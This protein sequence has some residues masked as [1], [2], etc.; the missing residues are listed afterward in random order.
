MNINKLERLVAV[1][2]AGSFRK[3][4][5]V[6]GLSQPAL[7]WSIR[8]LE[9]SLDTPL[10]ERGPRGAVPTLACERLI[11]RA[12]LVINAQQRLMAEIERNRGLE[13][14]E[15]GVHPAMLHS[16]FAQ[17]VARYYQSAPEVSLRIREGYSADLLADLQRGDLDLAVCA[18]PASSVDQPFVFEPLAVQTYSVVAHPAHPVFQDIDAGRPIP[19]YAWVQFDAPN[20]AAASRTPQAATDLL[21]QAGFGEDIRTVR[22]A[23][24][25]LIKLLVSEAGLL[26]FLAE[27]YIADELASGQLKRVTELQVEAPPIGIVQLE[28]A[29]ETKAMLRLKAI[30][31]R[32]GGQT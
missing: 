3:A 30:L 8:Q 4:A 29:Y 7:T 31:R 16:G 15:L 22:T 25:G 26:G 19:P 10:F 6:L 28:G 2:D 5:S 20:I 21:K 23:S 11:A 1:A 13:T 9:Q 27:A 24:M 18:A 17:G 32:L 12:K 14:I